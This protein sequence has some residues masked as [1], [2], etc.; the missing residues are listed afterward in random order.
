MENLQQHQAPEPR[1]EAPPLDLEALKRR[2]QLMWSAGDFGIIGTK[3]LVASEL[4]CE[5]VDLRAGERV[6]DVACGHGNTALA[7]A[8]RSA[9]ATGLDY[10]PALLE[11][12]RERAAAERLE[13]AWREGDAEALPFEAGAFD[14]VLS[15]FGIMFAPDQPRAARELLRVC[16]PGGRIGLACWTPESFPGEMFRTVARHRPPPPDAPVPTRWGTAGGLGA[17]LGA[18]VA[19]LRAERRTIDMRFASAEHFL[20]VF[21][22]WFGPMRTAFAALDAEGQAALSRDLLALVAKVDRAGGGSV[23]MPSEYLEVVATRR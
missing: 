6:L 10:V 17:L 2:Q 3:L 4:L 15:T 1:R 19:G 20:E 21:R 12:A 16:R 18:G 13:V 22:T 14:V 23:I 9:L 7:A 5:A 11:R 8:R